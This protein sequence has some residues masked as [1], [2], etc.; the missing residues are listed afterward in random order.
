MIRAAA[1]YSA[2]AVGA[3]RRYDAADTLLYDAMM[4]VLRALRGASRVAIIR[5]R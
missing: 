5:Q 2:A 3:L 4:R 1:S